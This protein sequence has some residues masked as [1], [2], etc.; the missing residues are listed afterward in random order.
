MAI[1]ANNDLTKGLRGRVGKW[2]V[3]RIVRGK[4][5]ASHAPRKPDPR[6][7]SAAQRLTRSTFREASAW[8]VRILLDPVKKQ[9]YADL[10]KADALPNAYTAAVR[11]YMREVAVKLMEGQPDYSVQ[12]NK[13]SRRLHSS[14]SGKHA[15]VSGKIDDSYLRTPI[16]TPK[17]PASLVP[18]FLLSPKSTLYTASFDAI[19]PGANINLN[20][21]LTKRSRSG[22][23]TP[24]A[25]QDDSIGGEAARAA[26][27]D[28]GIRATSIRNP[29][30]KS[31]HP[32]CLHFLKLPEPACH[33]DREAYHYYD[34]AQP[35]DVDEWFFEGANYNPVFLAT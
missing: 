8:A 16:R 2:M 13:D 30:P 32:L 21:A 25:V 9:Y 24:G 18:I 3:F 23:S 10:A 15:R 7:Q 6:K 29:E 19:L 27:Q 22:H 35:E 11:E 26:V 5:I 12:T 4:T 20:C 34:S 1:V 17:Y 14:H 31:F 28:D 33:G